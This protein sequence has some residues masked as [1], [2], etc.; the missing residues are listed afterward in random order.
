MKKFS[1]IFVIIVVIAL[2][3]WLFLYDEAAQPGSLSGYHSDV[4]KCEACHEPW[5]GVTDKQCLSCHDLQDA[6]SLRK[7]IRFHEA[8]TRCLTCH[9]E[10]R[11]LG[12]TI[13]DM[14]HTVLHED[15]LCTDCHFDRH[16]G[17]FGPE[18]RACHGITT[19]KIPGYRHPE[20]GRRDC[21]KCHK[22]PA[23][24]Y[25]E[26]F[27]TLILKDMTRKDVSAQDCWK[28]HTIRHWRHLVMEHDLKPS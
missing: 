9:K 3:V 28:C 4:E 1:Q 16:D 22:A 27:W 8:G 2:C 21:F 13:S 18:C 7:E 20:A 17:L 23:S 10:H 15:L 6:L 26:R 19:W 25:D 12:E 5:K 14:K 24:H 11:M